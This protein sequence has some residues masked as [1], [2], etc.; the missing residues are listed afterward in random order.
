MTG[1]WLEH[2][3]KIIYQGETHVGQSLVFKLSTLKIAT[4]KA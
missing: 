1:Q 2:K 3:A 4:V